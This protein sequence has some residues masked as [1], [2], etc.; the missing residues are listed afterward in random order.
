M[1]WILL[2]DTHQREGGNSYKLPIDNSGVWNAE[3]I[4]IPSPW[5]K[6][7]IKKEQAW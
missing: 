5:I 4:I 6:Q 7:I 1:Q 3:R 2:G